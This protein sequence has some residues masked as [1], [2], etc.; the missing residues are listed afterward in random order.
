MNESRRAPHALV[1]AAIDGLATAECGV[2]SVVDWF[3]ECVDEIADRVPRLR[4]RDWAL[5][6]I[7]PTIS[8]RSA[9]YAPDVHR[10]VS[11]ACQARDGRFIWL[12][13]SNRASLTDV[14]AHADPAQWE[15]MCQLLA[16]EV[17]RLCDRH[18]KVTLL[19]HGVM[20]A[21]VRSYLPN[22][23]NLQIVYITHS[24]G[25][26]FADGTSKNRIA[27][28]ERAFPAMRDHP[29]D[30]VGYI[31]PY[32]HDLLRYEYELGPR[33]LVPFVNGIP[34]KPTR[35]GASTVV[36]SDEYLWER[37]IPKNRRLLFS[38]GRCHAQ[39]GFDV[40]I[41]AFGEF[42]DRVD[43]QSWHLVALMPQGLTDPAYRKR[44]DALVAAAPPGSITAITSF[45]PQLPLHVLASRA[46][47]VAVFTSRF[48]GAPLSVLEA[49]AF[50][51]ADLRLVWHDTPSLGQ[52]L[53]QQAGAFRC[54]A[55]T[56][57]EVAQALVLAAE[58]RT[59]IGAVRPD[60]FESN[61]A[62]GLREALWWW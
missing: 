28:E 21:D 36:P 62:V 58:A 4:R 47:E 59:G 19:V 34:D 1:V 61:T 15:R 51:H 17:A 5:Y 50:G 40:L 7:S 29:L 26:A 31:G 23:A 60:S 55:L 6:A 22:M 44:I 13:N 10:L 32:F 39:K 8:S 20:L 42:L 57:D 35:F 14:W 12:D 41:P 38:W 30:R 52:F 9:D 48:E 37:G 53:D 49:Q 18:A 24:L 16:D 54:A 56:V 43:D 25:R 45:D 27:M 2:A 3:F 11:T 33:M 46:L